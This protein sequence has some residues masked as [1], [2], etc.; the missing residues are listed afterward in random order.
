MSLTEPLGYQANS[1][2][3][4]PCLSEGG[5]LPRSTEFPVTKNLSEGHRCE[6]SA[7]ST[8]SSDE[9]AIIEQ[10]S[11]AEMALGMEGNTNTSSQ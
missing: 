11:D 7:Y 6:T 8:T 4:R 1:Y 5:A 3:I 10:Y 9:S 2:S